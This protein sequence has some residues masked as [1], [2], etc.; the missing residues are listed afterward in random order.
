MPGSAEFSC[1]YA[2]NVFV[3][4]SEENLKKFVDNPRMY[5]QDG[6]PHMPPDYRLLVVGPRG[7]GTNTQAKN[8][9]ELYGWRIV[10]FTEIVR[11]KM[12]EILEMEEKLP[13]NVSE[14]GPCMICCSA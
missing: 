10:D 11:N 9:E 13:N 8:L 7:S 3:F 6:E 12:M 1:H 4:V 2:N 5:L 14:L